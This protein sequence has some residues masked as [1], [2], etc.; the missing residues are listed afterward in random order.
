[1]PLLPRLLLA[2][3]A[4]LPL[5]VAAQFTSRDVTRFYQ[6]YDAAGGCPLAASLQQGYL[7]DGSAGLSGFIPTASSPPTTWR[8]R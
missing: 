1:M 7:D 3:C 5:S 2:C 4:L 8:N 6:V